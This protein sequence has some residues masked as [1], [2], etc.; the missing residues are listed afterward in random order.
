MSKSCFIRICPTNFKKQMIYLNQVCNTIVNLIFLS[1]TH[2]PHSTGF[3]TLLSSLTWKHWLALYKCVNALHFL[4]I[5][6]NS[7]KF[8]PAKKSVIH[9]QNSRSITICRYRKHT[10]LMLHINTK[11]IKNTQAVS[12][13]ASLCVFSLKNSSRR[14]TG[15]GHKYI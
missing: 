12:L 13:N 2:T 4:C 1:H 6:M 15:L 8:D 10:D 14:S 7:T 9:R 11:Y 3:W 5:G